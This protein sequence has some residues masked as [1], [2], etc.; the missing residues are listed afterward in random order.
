MH[1]RLRDGKQSIRE[2]SKQLTLTPNVYAS[3]HSTSVYYAQDG[4][5]TF[6]FCLGLLLSL[7]LRNQFVQI[8]RIVSRRCDTPKSVPRISFEWFYFFFLLLFL[9]LAL[10]SSPAMPDG[11]GSKRKKKRFVWTTEGCHHF[12]GRLNFHWKIFSSF[13]QLSFFFTLVLQRIFFFA[14]L[15]ILCR[16]HTYRNIKYA[17]KPI[18]TDG[19]TRNAI[20][21]RTHACKRAATTSYRIFIGVVYYMRKLFPI[22]YRYIDEWI[23]KRIIL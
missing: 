1:I 22:D 4:L 21:A 13:F 16:R 2:V 23:Y 12:W 11:D 3:A 17:L 14:C 15:F 8:W 7:S 9:S 10:I 5:Q 6:C 20:P 18:D 19:S